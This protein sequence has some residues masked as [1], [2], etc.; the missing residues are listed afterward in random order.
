VVDSL[1]SG[2]SPDGAAI[3]ANAI[4]GGTMRVVN[5]TALNQTGPALLASPSFGPTDPVAPNDLE[6]TNSIARGATV[7]I[8]VN[9]LFAH[10]LGTIGRVGQIEVDHSDFA[11]RTPLATARDA[12]LITIGSGN[13]VA[14]PLFA[15]PANGNFHLRPG[16]PAIDAGTSDALAGPADLDGR[17]R[18][19]GRAPDLGAFETSPHR[20]G[21]PP[22]PPPPGPHFKPVLSNLRVRPGSIQASHAHRPAAR[23]TFTLSQPATVRLS[24]A[25]AVRN[26]RFV[27]AV[28]ITVRAG[29][30]ATTVVFTGALIR[31][32]P[33]GPG[34]YRLTATPAG[35]RARTARLTVLPR[36]G[37]RRA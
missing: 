18:V 22:P 27:S 17:V 20:I 9:D 28:S 19:Q 8:E 14:D 37:G 1:A 23:I 4:Q 36:T 26:G 13:V 33:L 5:T 11:T 7:D 2:T 31:R 16:S 32:R 12:A 3:D 10:P 29:R 24:F 15:D 6:V 35:G 34:I 25:R 21:P 30:G